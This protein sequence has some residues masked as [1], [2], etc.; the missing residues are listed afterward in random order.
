MKK[1]LIIIFFISAQI[2]AQS[3]WSVSTGGTDTTY[4]INKFDEAKDYTDTKVME[5]ASGVS[6]LSANKTVNLTSSMTATEIQDSINAQPKNLNG[7]TLTFQFADGTYT[8][9][10]GLNFNS[11]IGGTVNIFGNVSESGLHTNQTVIL[12]CSAD[13]RMILCTR[14][15]RYVISNIKFN[16]TH[17]TTSNVIVQ[18]SDGTGEINGCYFVNTSANSSNCI[19]S[20]SR[21][22]INNCYISGG[23]CGIYSYHGAM[24]YSNN[25]DDTGTQPAYGLR[26]T[27]AI[28]FK[29]GVNQPA[30][31]SGNESLQDGGQ[32]F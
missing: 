2:F 5:V 12:N 17:A 21:T 28:I 14:Y 24:V 15:S 11:F 16:H 1:L 27:G 8:L 23:N 9:S 29:A 22:D 4:V 18:I 10:T 32:I 20:A 19:I 7:F 3:S 25:N 30:G 31:S 26:A 6:V 13:S